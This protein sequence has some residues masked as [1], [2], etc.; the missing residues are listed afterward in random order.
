MSLT[1]ALLPA[2]GKEDLNLIWAGWFDGDHALPII[3]AIQQNRGIWCSEDIVVSKDEL[4]L[5]DE[6]AFDDCTLQVSE[7]LFI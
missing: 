3:R 5:I 1:P 4:R 6:R 7:R 2:F